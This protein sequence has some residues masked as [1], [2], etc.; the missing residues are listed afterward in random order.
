VIPAAVSPY[1]PQQSDLSENQSSTC[2]CSWSFRDWQSIQ[3]ENRGKRAWDGRVH[4]VHPS[5]QTYSVYLN[6]PAVN[7]IFAH[8]VPDNP[9]LPVV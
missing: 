7:P 9:R 4:R 3:H 5:A 2:F 8:F 1:W 6:F